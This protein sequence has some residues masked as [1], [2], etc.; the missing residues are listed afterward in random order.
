MLIINFID[1][2]NYQLFI[3]ILIN[4]F[5]GFYIISSNSRNLIQMSWAD[6]ISFYFLDSETKFLASSKMLLLQD[7]L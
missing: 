1:L 5:I 3:L 2:R 6:Q 4:S 7:M